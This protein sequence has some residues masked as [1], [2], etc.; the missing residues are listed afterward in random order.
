M[1]PRLKKKDLYLESGYFNVSAL[2]DCGMP[3]NFVIGGRG[4]GKTFGALKEL[5][6]RKIKFMYMRRTKDQCSLISTPEFH[7]Y[8]DHNNELGWNITAQKLS[9][10]HGGFYDTVEDSEGGRVPVGNPFAYTGSLG[11]VA[12]IR[13]VSLSDI[14][15]LVF[16]EFIPE[17]HERAIKEEG[18]ALMNACET[19]GR[20]RELKGRPPLQLIALTNSNDMAPDVFV[21]LRLVSVLDGMKRKKKSVYQDM[22]RGICMLLLDDSPI[23]ETKRETSLYRLTKGT[24]F[25]SMSLD[26]DFSNNYP[27]VNPRPLAEYKPIV[28]VG[29]LTI[30]SHKSSGRLYVSDHLSGG[31]SERYDTDQQSLEVFR[32][33]YR[34]IYTAYLHGLVEFE[35]AI[36]CVLFDKYV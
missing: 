36:C 9:P 33:K 34:P 7:P 18:F 35:S 11:H 31:V 32:M 28:T 6:E 21:Q 24:R 30:Y 16:D 13:G 14:D 3:Y 4:T 23:S 5:Y 15:V 8:K 22:E 27:F 17:P 1:W 19:I 12:K 25:L 26:N 10:F 20:N 2:L 29:E